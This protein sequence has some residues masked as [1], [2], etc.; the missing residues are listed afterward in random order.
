MA[1]LRSVFPG[2]QRINPLDI[3]RI[4]ATAIRAIEKVFPHVIQQG[5]HPAH[6]GMEATENN[7]LAGHVATAKHLAGFPGLGHLGNP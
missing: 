3:R 5:S 6:A 4:F 7:L 1:W 2:D